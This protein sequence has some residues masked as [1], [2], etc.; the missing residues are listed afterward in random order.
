VRLGRW[1]AAAAILAWTAMAGGVL[2]QGNAPQVRVTLSPDMVK[3]GEPVRYRVE[4]I[5]GV[6]VWSQVQWLAPDTSTAFTWGPM[7]HGFSKGRPNQR[8][9][10]GGAA[11]TPRIDQGTPDTSWVELPLQVFTLGVVQVPGIEFRYQATE[12][13]GSHPVNGRAPTAQLVVLP[14]LAQRDTSARLS[15]V[16][17]PLAAPWWER[18]PWA[19]V[20]IAV[21]ALVLVVWL[22][23]A[24]RRRRR[25]A[26]AAPV[27]TPLE[28]AHAA[29]AALAELRALDL[30]AHQRFAEH[31]FRLGQ[32]LRR[33]LEALWPMTRPGDTTPEL[34][35]HLEAEGL[36]SEDVRRLAGL[37]RVWDRVKFA[38]E[39]LTV[40][41]AHRAES[42]VEAF[43][44]RGPRSLP[45]EAA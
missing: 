17:G 10:F 41:E 23:R 37:L 39:P 16:H 38:R 8:P 42:A 30:P 3:L 13:G 43:V 44:R 40:D 25:A 7:R 2:A 21:A 6:S 27:I 11:R 1:L 18:V 33:Y 19:W 24:I 12:V 36:S 15:G 22:V 29:L 32:I 4:V 31:A 34:V 35:R 45:Q 20:A 26:P 28:P 9:R 5:G 14:T